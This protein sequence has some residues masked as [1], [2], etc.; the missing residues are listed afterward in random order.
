LTGRETRQ[1]LAA[2]RWVA[3]A[4]RVVADDEHRD[5]AGVLELAELVE[6]DRVAQVDVGSRGV[7][8]ELDPQRAALALG[9]AELALERAFGQHVDGADHEIVEEAAVGHGSVLSR[10]YGEPRAGRRRW[11]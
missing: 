11:A 4:R 2:T 10:G 5:V 1:R 7:D 6:D 3:D 8:A 9:E